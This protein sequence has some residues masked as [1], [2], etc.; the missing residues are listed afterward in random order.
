MSKIWT[1]FISTILQAI[2]GMLDL[3]FLGTV[4]AARRELSPTK[5]KSMSLQA[6]MVVTTLG[7]HW[8]HGLMSLI[9]PRVL[10]LN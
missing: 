5:V 9:L 7:Q 6:M 8:L 10:G 3:L 4:I 2:H 1:I